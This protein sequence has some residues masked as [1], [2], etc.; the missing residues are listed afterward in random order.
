MFERYGPRLKSGTGFG[1]TGMGAVDAGSSTAARSTSSPSELFRDHV[2]GCFID[3]VHGA[4]SIEE[5]GVDNVMA[6]CDYPHGDTSWPNTRELIRR[7]VAHLDDDDQA[8]VLAGNA[9][10]VF[11]LGGRTRWVSCSRSA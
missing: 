6:E 7:Q 2:F 10:R 4:S 1:L 3:D 5:I 9:R 11:G 8:K